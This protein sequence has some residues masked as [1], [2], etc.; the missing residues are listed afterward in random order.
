MRVG[1]VG[2]GLA[3][4]LV[5]PANAQTTP[6][7]VVHVYA[8]DAASAPVAA[9]VADALV[10]R[11]GSGG[12]WRV[13]TEKSVND[14]IERSPEDL[15]RA[16]EAV[17]NART[18]Y[19]EGLEHNTR[20]RLELA[21]EM[22][23]RARGSFL[24]AALPTTYAELRDVHLY[25]GV[26]L[27]NQGHPDVASQHFRQAAFLA[28]SLSLN[29]D[30]FSPS[31]VA[32][33][34]LAKRGVSAGPKGSLAVETDAPNATMWLDGVPKGAPR[35]LADLPEG[36]HY[37][38][39]RAP[40]AQ[41][42][43]V[44]ATVTAGSVT[45]VPVPMR[46]AALSLKSVWQSGRGE[47]GGV[48]IARILKV[49]RFVLGSVR[50]TV[51]GMLPHTA[52]AA[53]FEAES[54]RRFADAE[55]GF[56]GANDARLPRFADSLFSKQQ[57]AVAARSAV[58][59]S[60]ARFLE[61]DRGLATFETGFAYQNKVYDHKGRY[62]AADSWGQFN[63]Y[64]PDQDFERY[65]ETRTVVSARYGL[66]DRVTAVVNVPF[67]TKELHYIFDRNDNGT[68]E[69]GEDDVKR[70][71]SG[72]GDVSMGAD[73]RIPR[74]EVGPLS[75]VYTAGR[76]ELP[77]GSSTEE[78]GFIRRYCS[79]VIGSGQWDVYL[80][81]GG[82]LAREDWRFGFEAGYNV[83][84][85]DRVWYYNINRPHRHLDPGDEQKIRLD[86]AYHVGRLLAPELFLDIMRRDATKKFINPVTHESGTAPEMLLVDLGAA[87]RAE[88]TEKSSGG[89]VVSHPIYGKTT[90]TFFPLDVTG[91]RA[92]LYYGYRF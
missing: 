25:L 72:V 43:L 52:R 63:R 19:Q 48:A 68:I 38:E 79:L 73:V 41:P 15:A 30:V 12:R 60:R 82:L 37:I 86:G 11:G 89:L 88:F 92:Y 42:Q 22:L 51:A 50:S 20:L 69:G 32:A 13:T 44:A 58:V 29:R 49:D 5:S 36:E 4:L 84:L 7:A 3:L 6:N 45:P 2:L 64:A 78:C 46:K 54:G 8:E 9:Q 90:M 27:F 31:V 80:G 91:P 87:L 16:A 34:E 70:E 85:P 14:L 62:V 71:D 33:F 53:A 76:V 56:S 35:L 23:Q 75:M 59:A 47:A 1:L 66:R 83:R 55:T 17:A 24:E 67:Y 39:V 57:V 21:Q 77:T 10:R 65:F 18:S 61:R 81:M 26:I 28:P 74:F 40:G